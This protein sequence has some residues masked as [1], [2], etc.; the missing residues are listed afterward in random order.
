MRDYF[1]NI[2][3]SKKIV[4]II[5]FTSTYSLLLSLL[6]HI[7]FDIIRN[8]TSAQNTLYT[9]AKIIAAVSTEILIYDDYD[10]ASDLLHSLSADPNIFKAEIINI[11]G[12]IISTY[13]SS[14]F[15]VEIENSD[16]FFVAA[17]VI[18]NKENIG[19]V[20]L[21]SN[22]N[23][24]YQYIL[25][26]FIIA[27]AIFINVLLI[28]FFI[29]Y[30]LQ[31]SISD[32]ILQLAELAKKVASEHNYSLRA[33]KLGDDEIGR[34]A[35]SFN[36]LLN[37]VMQKDN[38]LKSQVHTRTAKIEKANAAKREF[39]AVISHEI[40]TPMNA[41]IGFSHLIQSTRLS[42]SQ[43]NYIKK[44]DRATSYLLSILTD[45]LDF[46]KV[47]A[48]KMELEVIPIDFYDM[49]DNVSNTSAAYVN[50]D[51]ARKNDID[52]I[53][54]IDPLIP[55]T[56]NA[57]PLRLSQVLITLIN[58]ALKFTRNGVVVV[59]INVITKTKNDILLDFS[60]EDTGIGMTDRQ[61]LN[62]FN[63]FSQA[64]AS[65]VR[66]Y[67]GTGLGLAI[68]KRMINLMGGEISVTSVINTGSKFNFQLTFVHSGL[69]TPPYGVDSSVIPKLDI[70]LISPKEQF[71]ACMTRFG[72]SMNFDISQS[73]HLSTLCTHTPPQ[74]I[75]INYSSLIN[76]EKSI[77]R[78][79]GGKFNKENRSLLFVMATTDI[80]NLP[81][82][83]QNND[84]IRLIY[85]PILVREL[86][87]KLLEALA[88]PLPNKGMYRK[89][90]YENNI[91]LKNIRIL[92]VEDNIMNQ[93]LMSNILKNNHAAVDVANDG[94]E[95]VDI[96]T[97]NIHSYDFI[98]MDIQMPIMDGYQATIA[99]RF[100][101]HAKD[102]PIIAITANPEVNGKDMALKVGFSSYLTKP[103]NIKLLFET[104]S[105]YI[106]VEDSLTTEQLSPK[107]HRVNS[108]GREESLAE[109]T[110]NLEGIS[111]ETLRSNTG[112]N[113]ELILVLYST[114]RMTYK[115]IT[116]DLNDMFKCGKLEDIMKYCHKLKGITT[117]LGAFALNKEIVVLEQKSKGNLSLDE[118]EHSLLLVEQEF[119]IVVRSS[120]LLHKHLKTGY[121][122]IN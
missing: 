102:I 115:N 106:N 83:F 114:F 41:I 72:Q 104:L 76:C 84:H 28:A 119:D 101:P 23:E 69:I 54:D 61:T 29:S 82:E 50:E 97:N 10:A 95:A 120:L 71:F 67:G 109:E 18:E 112:E 36:H 26:S 27:G 63:A 35:E 90:A 1:T 122:A 87:Y 60:V 88:L 96:V 64:D 68:C 25:T 17:N 47:D 37:K 86:L 89:I 94:Q 7:T 19:K 80:K 14:K 30:R 20:V 59:S 13:I 48:N 117:T 65:T 92:L 103:I 3:I 107:P 78:K 16:L 91:N 56:I 108:L 45:I 113:I 66:N 49:I 77:I 39:L 75:L 11:E 31:K 52:V 93:Q 58:N 110:I 51:V 6:S 79:I 12:V 55:E 40:R 73:K 121:D 98:L 15:D 44:I 53:F 85:K 34:L 43:Y 74:V 42:S 81:L 8:S 118:F 38:E 111:V 46:S 105:S 57:D 99:I 100:L 9:Q 116:M 62:L 5:I 32:P 70:L 33:N 24:L 4:L 2:T 22:D 21:Y